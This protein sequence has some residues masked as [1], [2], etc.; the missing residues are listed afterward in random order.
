MFWTRLYQGGDLC[1]C[2]QGELNSFRV[3]LI[4][5]RLDDVSLWLSFEL[6]L[7][8]DGVEPLLPLLEGRR[9]VEICASSMIGVEPFA[10]S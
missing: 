9:L 5:F 10:S 6:S 7:F 1:A 2:V 4:G 3:S 8:A